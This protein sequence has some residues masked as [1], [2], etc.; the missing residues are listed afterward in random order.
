MKIIQSLWTKPLYDGSNLIS[1]QSRFSGG[2]LSHKHF[3]MA[4]SLSCLTIREQYP[5]INLITDKKG[6]RLLIND[7]QLPYSTALTELDR[8]NSYPSSLWAIPKVFSYSLQDKPFVHIDNDIFIWDKILEHLRD[9][10]I[11]VQNF[12]Y[13]TYDYAKILEVMYNSFSY[14]PEYLKGIN[15]SKFVTGEILVDTATYESANAGIFGGND[16]SFIKKYTDEVFKTVNKNKAHLDDKIGGFVNVVLE[17][18]IFYRYAR[19]HHKRI[20]PFINEAYFDRFTTLVNFEYA[21]YNI[22]YIHTLGDFKKN[23]GICQQV[24]YRLKYYYPDQHRH[25]LSYMKSIGIEYEGI[26]ERRF[27]VFSH[28]LSKV[29]KAKDIEA[30]MDLPLKLSEGIKIHKKGKSHFIRGFEDENK[31]DAWNKYLLHFEDAT[32]TGNDLLEAILESDIS[33]HFDS[34]FIRENI[35]GTLCQHLTY[36]GYL[37]VDS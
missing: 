27:S 13:L 20:S 11:I 5:D 7:L 2:W 18:L 32:F 26:D 30:A 34:T 6:K 24:E 8:F 1:E 10:D 29:A 35:Y 31:L 3:L 37:T 14:L 17:Q 9:K 22:K 28:N 4:M 15:I 33:N 12:E 36:T 19:I 21:P 25:I 16:I 23:E